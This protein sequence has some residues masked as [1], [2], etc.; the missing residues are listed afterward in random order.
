MW[1]TKLSY[2]FQEIGMWL[3][4]F[5]ALFPGSPLTPGNE[6]NKFVPSSISWTNYS[7]CPCCLVSHIKVGL[8]CIIC[9]TNFSVIFQHYSY[10][11]VCNS[12][13]PINW[14]KQP[15]AFYSDITYRSLGTCS[16]LATQ[17]HK[18]EGTLLQLYIF[19]S[20]CR[21]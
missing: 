9:S 8:S 1:H 21:S 17:T 11:H 19:S 18:K 14:L 6:A 5:V 7:I 10:I 3:Y 12:D 15:K 20:K 13:N 16:Q 4:K 2:L